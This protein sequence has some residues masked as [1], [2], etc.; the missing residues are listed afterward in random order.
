MLRTPLRR[1]ALCASAALAALLVPLSAAAELPPEDECP[2]L[3]GIP[4]AAADED[5][6][7]FR[8]RE[9][10]QLHFA[11]V[12]L[13]GS[14]LPTE[15]WRNRDQFFHE[16]MRLEVGPCHRR[17]RNA[18]FFEDA[19][20]RFAGQARV[21][22]EGNLTGHVAGLPFPPE[23]IDPKAPDAG[24]RWAWNVER[25]YRGAGHFGSFRILDMP[26]QLGGI[27]T[28]RGDWFL[29]QTRH[30][31]DLPQSDFAVPMAAQSDWV[32]GGLFAEPTSARHL[33]WR[34]IRPLETAQ[35]YSKPDDTFVYVPTMRKMRRA[36]A[37]WVDGM[38]VPRYRISGDSGGGALPIGGDFAPGGAINPTAGESIAVTENLRRG[39]TGL[40]L[41]PNA[42]TWRI[43][44]YREVLAPLNITRS[45]YPDDPDRN[46]GASGLSV[47]NDRWDV[48]YAVVL[49]G[50]LKERGRD[51]DVLTLWVDY[52][53]QQPLY[54]MTRRKVGQQL[55]E[56]GILLHRYSGDLTRYPAWPDG[57]K[58]LVFDPVAAVFFDTADGGSGWR[59]ESYDVTSVP[60]P[61][62]ELRRLTTPNYLERGH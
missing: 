40:A 11:D 30:R 48:R 46:F 3:S 53:T 59:R 49:Q 14:L 51:Y 42:Y 33:A 39:F 43:L 32:A 6:T 26:S 2:A 62:D 45:G 58:A 15:V 35:H 41:R 61:E 4:G 37:G 57:Q 19:T 36:A 55:L 1:R 10:M 38:Y 25:R 18:A 17:Y 23:Q 27:Q 44:D 52:Q 50:M 12:L 54:V 5:A 60:P 28:F 13:L 34:Q 29:L 9:G 31:A 21:D 8:L 22:K 20:K 16:G 7:P 47:G 56:V 24:L